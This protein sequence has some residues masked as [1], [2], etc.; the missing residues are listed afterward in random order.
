VAGELSPDTN[1]SSAWMFK[2]DGNGN[3]QWQGFANLYYG[4]SSAESIQQTSDGGYMVAG[5]FSYPYGASDAWISKLDVNGNVQ[6]AKAYGGAGYN[7]AYS[8]QQIS[9]GGYIV[10]GV[11]GSFGAA[12]NDAWMFK[13]DGSGNMQGQRTYGGNYSDSTYSIQQTSDGGYVLAGETRSFGAGSSNAWVLKVDATGEILSGC[14]AMGTSDATEQNTWASRSAT[15]V[16]GTDTSISPQTNTVLT[17]AT[18]AMITEACPYEE[19]DPAITYT[20]T[21]NSYAC[22]SCSG[23]ALRYSCETGAK[24]EFSFAGTGIRWIIA[25]AP[26]LG[27]AK[28]CLDGT[29]VCKTVDFYSATTV[30]QQIL[31]KTGIISGTHILSIE[32]LGEKNPS[33]TNYCIDIDAFQVVP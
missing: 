2:I 29:V 18:T 30:F 31:Q 16:E 21:W 15:V 5:W 26:M 22:S 32:V 13:L 27:K 19:N 14:S 33:A 3:M 17:K 12:T 25:K 8:V 4:D 10:A 28:A 24:A 1:V 23:G 20:G 6:W 7:Y 11:T 9:D